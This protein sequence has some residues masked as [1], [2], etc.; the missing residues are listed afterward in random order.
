MIVILYN[1]ETEA[2]EAS[3]LVYQEIIKDYPFVSSPEGNYQINFPN[4]QTTNQ[5]ALKVKGYYKDQIINALGLTLSIMM[6]Y[7]V[8]RKTKI[9]NLNKLFVFYNIV[10]FFDIIGLVIA[11]II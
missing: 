5:W 2:T 6:C 9:S 1:T 10:M 3:S 11:L 7:L 8:P 4:N